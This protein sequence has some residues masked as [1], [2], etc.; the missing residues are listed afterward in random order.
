MTTIRAPASAAA[1]AA[2]TVSSVLPENELAITS[3]S[4]PTHAGHS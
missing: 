4:G 3:V 1:V 2:P